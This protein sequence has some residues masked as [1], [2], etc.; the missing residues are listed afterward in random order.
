[1]KQPPLDVLKHEPLPELATAL[2]E[3][4]P[5]VLSIW[6]ERVI[7]VLPHADELTRKQLD[8]S[9]PRLLDQLADALAATQA[10]P[11]ERMIAD[12]PTHGETRFHQEFNINELMIDYQILRRTI[13]EELFAKLGRPMTQSETIGLHSGLDVAMR[14]AASEFA[15]HLSDEITTEAE[16][17]S[18]YLSF[19]SHDLRGGLNG[20]ILMIEVLK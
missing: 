8:N 15:R 9:I 7:D 13:V 11:T 10:A 4:S 16:T 12:A 2:R 1:M 19:L 18:K 17:M 5:Q 3:C 14:Q 20:A 6:R